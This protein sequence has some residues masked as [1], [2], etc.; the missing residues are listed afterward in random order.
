MKAPLARIVADQALGRRASSVRRSRKH[1]FERRLRQPGE[2]AQALAQGGLERQFATHGALGDGGDLWLQVEDV[3]HLVDAFLLDD[4]RVHVGDQQPLAPFGGRYDAD[5]DGLILVARRQLA[6]KGR[7]RAPARCMYGDLTGLGRRQP[8]RLADAARAGER[9]DLV[10]DHGHAGRAVGGADHHQDVRRGH[11][12]SLA[13]ARRAVKRLGR[14]RKLSIRCTGKNANDRH[15]R[16]HRPRNPRQP[17]QSDRR[18]RR[19]ARRRRDG[20][21]RGAVRR[22]DR[23]AR[24]GRTARRRQDPLSAARACCKAVEAVNGEIFD[25]LLG[26]GRRRPARHRRRR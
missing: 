16:H 9:R 26:H 21:R 5:V 25:A 20:P 3:G 24:G 1:G 11:R 15:R 6:A 8:A 13:P 14:I 7:R 17:R 23:R 22:L 10:A 4:G 18:G 2:Q 12:C 19:G